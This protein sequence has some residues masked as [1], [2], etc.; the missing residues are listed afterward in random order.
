[1]DSRGAL[2][3]NVI[4]FFLC[5]CVNFHVVL[6]AGMLNIHFGVYYLVQIGRKVMS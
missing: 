6:K 3:K 4:F 1:M 2:K 5:L